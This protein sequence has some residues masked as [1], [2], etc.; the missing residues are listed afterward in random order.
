L[1]KKTEIIIIGGTGFIGFH[2]A[3]KCTDMGWNVTSL[4]KNYPKK[5]RFIKKVNYIKCDITKKKL[6][7]KKLK[8]NFEYVVN[9]GGNVDHSNSKD[10]YRAHYL[11]LKNLAEIFLNK[12][13]KL[14]VQIGSGGE[15]GNAKVPHKEN[16]KCIPQSVYYKSKFLSTNYL[17][18]LY[19]K[20]NFPIVVFR[21]YQAY[22]PYQDINRI[23]PIVINNC[24]ANKKFKCSDGKQYRDFIFIDDIISAIVTSFGNKNS[25]GE[26]FNLGSGNLIQVR[27]IIEYINKKINKGLPIYGAINL[28]K[29]ELNKVYPSIIKIKNKLNWR[30]KN[31]LT[32]GLIKTINYYK[33]KYA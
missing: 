16:L 10:T 19:K 6:L 3:K 27:K 14:F 5:I 28:R 4:S 23:V 7:Q 31:S 25:L 29:D 9:L 26:I 11:G 18:N 33:K 20:K 30:P 17:L 32:K 2:L 8:K 21:I 15:Y 12:P 24:L 13:L 1:K 22:G